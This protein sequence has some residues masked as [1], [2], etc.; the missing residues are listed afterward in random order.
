MST[1]VSF[2]TG[3]AATVA[4]VAG[5]V[6]VF[7][8]ERVL[9]VGSGRV[10]LAALGVAVAVGAT[11]W[12]VVRML[13]APPARRALERWV[14]ALYALG[15]GAL[16]LYFLQ[17]DVGT[18][19]FGAPLSRSAPRLAGVLAV[20]F[21]ALLVCALLPLA[22]VEAALV[23]MAR[24]PVPET[25]RVRSA[26]FSGLG[27]A[28]VGVFAF[29]ATYVAT[30]ADATWDLSY[31]R[32]A[33]PGEA[34]R[35]RVLGLNEPLQVTLFFP[36][37][38]EVGEAVR[39]YFRDLEP[40]SPLL[41]VESLDQAVEPA[42]G[43]ALGVSNNG[44][45]V[46]SRGDRK[47]VLTLGLDMERARG[48]LQRLD[49]EVQ[50]RMLSVA[51]PRRIV[52]LTGGHGE[53]ADTRPVP[54]EA[55][56]PSVA[57]FKELLRAQNVD[58]RTLTAAEGLGT[59]VPRDAALVAVLGPTSELRPEETTALQEYWMQGGRLWIALEPD[60]AALEPL[61]KPM[62]LRSLRVPLANDRV[63][64]RTTRQV[65][66][67]GNLGTAS[68]SSHPSVT[69]MS[70]LGSQ[71][72]VAFP[73]AVALELVS[74]PVPGVKLDTSV[75]AQAETFADLNGD[76]E[77]QAGEVTR[78]WPLVVA[79]ERPAAGEGKPAPR[80]VVMADAD[81]LGDGILGNV[82]NAYLAVDTLRWL[83]GEEALSG[84]TTSEE[85]VPLQHTRSQ[86]VAW[87]YATVFLAPVVVL[88]VGFFVTRR[89]GRRA[90]R[91]AAAVGG[92]R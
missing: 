22:L 83:S 44:S 11:G 64:F 33:R 76:F 87:F 25:G 18:A 7:L 51:K 65:S 45:V 1:P 77:P 58:V 81:A 80:A 39:Q 29:A 30:K 85:D 35:K 40:E 71:A 20:L 46:L 50:R 5:L 13:A 75:R 32:T 73:G 72:A 21:P 47:E 82:G 14:L 38:N 55:A 84:A 27:M 61:L 91:S 37:A 36:P 59:E 54:G 31:F 12:R 79:V 49:A 88:A 62:G 92:A 34:T 89:R 68:F 74:P 10:A 41:S 24:A 43:K 70:A 15:L 17:G 56:R 57:Q 53:R 52:Y 6:A 66:D 63:Y 69:S 78:A 23:A 60:G 42:R 2:G 3:L 16:V 48:Q 19:L 9:G 86:D 28:F 26:L 4:F 67:R 90:P 8:A